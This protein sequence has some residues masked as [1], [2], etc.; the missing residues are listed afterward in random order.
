MIIITIILILLFLCGV[1]ELITCL[2]YGGYT[3]ILAEDIKKAILN[4]K[5]NHKNHNIISCN[6]IEGV[7]F[8][9]KIAFSFMSAY[10]IQ[11]NNGSKQIFRFGNIH[12]LIKEKHK[13]LLKSFINKGA[14]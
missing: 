7:K 13:E 4:S 2:T 9:A 12:K 10:Y 5:L 14:R 3:K 6:D 8:I 1:F 11:F